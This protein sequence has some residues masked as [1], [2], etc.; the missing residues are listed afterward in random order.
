MAEKQKGQ[1]WASVIEQGMK[2]RANRSGSPGEAGL[3]GR[4]EAPGAESGVASG[5]G[6][7]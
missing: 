5:H 3:E 6:Q 7:E 4:Q 1:I 2:Q